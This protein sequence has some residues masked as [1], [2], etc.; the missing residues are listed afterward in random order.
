MTHFLIPK[1]L[2]QIG[3]VCFGIFLM[4]I[5]PD[6]LTAHAGQQESTD[7]HS[8]CAWV[9]SS[10]SPAQM[11]NVPMLSPEPGDDLL[12]DEDVNIVTGLYTR[13]YSRQQNGLIDYKTARQIVTSEYNEYWNTVVH[14]K[15]FPL[16]YWEDR[17]QDGEFNMWVD[18]QGDGFPCDIIPYHIQD[19]LQR[20]QMAE[21]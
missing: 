11:I 14:T 2:M 17:N 5:T 20:T 3:G 21:Y 16:L 18:Q 12:I 6:I 4:V 13:S 10:T 19:N 15:E 8:Q 1:I 9:S 7:R